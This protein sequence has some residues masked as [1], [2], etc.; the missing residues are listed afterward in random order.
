MVTQEF[1]QIFVGFLR[2]KTVKGHEYFYWCNRV[3][4]RKKHGGSGKVKSPDLLIGNDIVQGKYLPFYLYMGE[5]PLSEYVA[6]AIAY[7]LE[8]DWTIYVNGGKLKMKDVA[9]VEIDWHVKQPKVRLRSLDKRLDC[10]RQNWRQ[11]KQKLHVYLQSICQAGA[12]VTRDIEYAAYCLA[13]YETYTKEAQACQNQMREYH[14]NPA[15]TWT[16]WQSIKNEI[17]GKWNQREVTY[18]WKEDAEQILDEAATAYD[19]DA[20]MYWEAYQKTLKQV[21]SYAPRLRQEGFRRTTGS[22]IEKLAKDIHWI[23]R[24][25]HR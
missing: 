15:K 6:A 3:R 2:V 4:S 23:E 1:E 17:T 8:T 18:N 10:R 19:K 20:S 9:T 24:Y 14:K 5:V 21:I 25:E 11:V 7:L 22:Q 12:R 16:E 13:K